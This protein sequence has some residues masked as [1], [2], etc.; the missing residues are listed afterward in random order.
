MKAHIK[1]ALRAK[2][3]KDM[4]TCERAVQAAEYNGGL[5]GTNSLRAVFDYESQVTQS[6]LPGIQG[7]HDIV[8][9]D[10]GM[11]AWKSYGIGVGVF[12]SDAQ[13]AKLAK[14]PGAVQGTTGCTLVSYAEL[15]KTKLPS[16][17]SVPTGRGRDEPVGRGHASASEDGTKREASGEEL[18]MQ[19]SEEEGS[20]ED[21]MQERERRRH[22]YEE[23]SCDEMEG[24]DKDDFD[25]DEEGEEA[26]CNMENDSAVAAGTTPTTAPSVRARRT[27][28]VGTAV[29]IR[30]KLM[31][32]ATHKKAALE[33]AAEKKARKLEA[34]RILAEKDRR[35]V[36][37]RTPYRCDVCERPF[38][39]G[40]EFASH[41]CRAPRSPPPSEE[42][43]VAPE[44]EVH[45]STHVP[46]LP[47]GH[48]LP[49][50]RESTVMDVVVDER[51][52]ALYQLGV[53]KGSNRQ[54]V[55]DMEQ[56]LEREFPFTIA[57][58]RHARQPANARHSCSS[59]RGD[60][61]T[62]FFV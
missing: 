60:S 30:S 40:C 57:P 51:L 15:C 4:A 8:F 42:G 45:D 27:A 16:A 53:K 20:E 25:F 38:L 31:P 62:V 36:L 6:A 34:A 12:F 28:P 2:H 3:P 17:A 19:G 43:E 29:R 55:F 32:S 13:L 35:V 61:I 7:F 52:E 24:E 41:V 14:P 39:R 26:D 1:A 23:A 11:R 22:T 46:A 33:H 56:T 18:H 59:P 48:G 49:P 50:L 58:N 9:E 47:Q 37:E 5:P 10:G 44:E 54:G 21:V